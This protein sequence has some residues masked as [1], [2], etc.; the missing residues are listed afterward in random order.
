MGTIID[1]P[2]WLPELDQTY[3]STLPGCTVTEIRC[4]ARP[5]PCAVT[6]NDGVNDLTVIANDQRMLLILLTA[7]ATAKPVDITYG[8]SVEYDIDYNAAPYVPLV[9]YL[10]VNV[11]LS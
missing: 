2:G 8:A 11:T 9:G 6:V 7:F 10:L 5:V 3:L 4:K 1:V